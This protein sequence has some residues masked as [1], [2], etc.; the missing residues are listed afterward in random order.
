MTLLRSDISEA[1]RLLV[2]AGITDDALFEKLVQAVGSP[3]A[4]REIAR[5]IAEEVPGLPGH[6]QNWLLGTAPRRD[7]SLATESQQRSVDEIIADLLIDSVM[8]SEK[9]ETAERDV[10]PE[11]M[12]VVPR[13]ANSMVSLVRQ[14]ESTLQTLRYIAEKRSLRVR[15]KVGEEVD[16]SPLEHEMV[17]GPVPGV[18]RVRVVRP[19]VEAMSHDGVARI[20]RKGLVE[21]ASP[22]IGSTFSNPG[23]H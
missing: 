21:P 5:K 6:V 8:L 4:A 7:S 17:G 1:L 14:C 9:A 2:R 23:G 11:I 16:F 12:V 15:G 18:R 10:L 3:Q 13:L 20:V 22:D 19:V